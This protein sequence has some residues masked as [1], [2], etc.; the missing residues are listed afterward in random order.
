MHERFGVS[1]LMSMAGYNYNIRTPLASNVLNF[2]LVQ[3]VT[4]QNNPMD[5]LTQFS[6]YVTV[7]Q[8]SIW[9]AFGFKV[10][11]I[12]VLSINAAAIVQFSSSDVKVAIVGIASASMPPHTTN[13]K[14]M[15]L[16]AELGIVAALDITGGS[17]TCQAQL[18]P[19][20]FV[21]YP[22]KQQPIAEIRWDEIDPCF[23]HHLEG[24]ITPLWNTNE[25]PKS[26]YH[27]LSDTK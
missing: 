5:T 24:G 15:F 7:E 6:N 9:L 4:A 10:D 8:D 20:S 19:N 23:G 27:L 26:C 2:P 22:G 25:E 17:L 14:E 1:K 11:A 21:L 3:G 18:T 13:R 12:Q 16:Y